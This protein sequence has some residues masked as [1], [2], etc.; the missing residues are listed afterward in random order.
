MRGSRKIFLPSLLAAP[1]LALLILSGC[2]DTVQSGKEP[3]PARPAKPVAAKQVVSAETS[4]FEIKDGVL[5]RY[6]G[7]YSKAGEIVLPAEVKQIAGRAFQLPEKLREQ[8][9]GLLETQKL[10]IPAGV[11]LQEEAFYGC[12]PLEVTLEEG[13]EFIEEKAFYECT[14]YYSKVIVKVPDTVKI[15]CQHAFDVGQDGW[16]TVN[17][18]KGVDSLEPYALQGA[19]AVSLP[20]S[21]R[22]IG[23]HALGDW[24]KIPGGLPEGVRY[25][26]KHFVDLIQ[27][28]LKV[29]ASVRHIAV[30]AA[31]WEKEA[32]KIGYQVDSA[33]KNYRSDQN[34][35]LYSKD[36]KTLYFAYS[37]NGEDIKIPDS[38]HTV[39]TKGLMTEENKI[40][41]HGLK[42]VK[43]ID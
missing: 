10:M 7:D 1:L 28:R 8:P 42:R 6:L 5:V 36:G 34:G 14:K 22:E 23:K 21:I 32:R 24:G 20:D 15:I 35:W 26:E 2:G 39:Y 43:R 13:R 40:K 4:L 11:K 31:V 16:L 25:L 18:G 41:V 27:G 38:V 17:L 30:G 33:N 37:L 29:P 12:G 3:V 19:Y 9:T